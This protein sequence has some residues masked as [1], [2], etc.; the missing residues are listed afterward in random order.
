[1]PI[2]MPFGKPARSPN[3]GANRPSDFLDPNVASISN[4]HN[5]GFIGRQTK[6]QNEWSFTN[7]ADR[8]TVSI[9]PEEG[10]LARR[11]PGHD[12]TVP[13]HAC[14]SHARIHHKGVAS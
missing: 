7:P 2:R 13:S 9:P 3:L 4:Q 12:R 6:I 8:G 1:L 14:P 10:A 5:P 11:P